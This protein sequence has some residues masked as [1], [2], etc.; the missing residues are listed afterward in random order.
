MQNTDARGEETRDEITLD[1]AEPQMRP[2]DG[3]RRK[4]TA[5]L[6]GGYQGPERRSGRDR[7]AS[8]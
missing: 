5:A 1:T 2:R 8:P 7:R 6:F 4:D 3:D